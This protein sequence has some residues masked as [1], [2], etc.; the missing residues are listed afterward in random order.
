MAFGKRHSANPEGRNLSRRRLAES[1]K[2]FYNRIMRNTFFV[3]FFSSFLAAASLFLFVSGAAAE[4]EDPCAGYVPPPA[5]SCPPW[6]EYT[7]GSACDGQI[8]TRQQIGVAVCVS[9]GPCGCGGYACRYTPTPWGPTGIT[10]HPWQACAPQ[11]VLRSLPTFSCSGACLKTPENPRYYDNPE[12]SNQ[13]DK[14][15]DSNNI[16]LPVKLDWDDIEGWGQEDG[17]QSYAMTIDNTKDGQ[18]SKVLQI[19]E[20]N[21]RQENGA[22]FLNSNTDVKWNVSGC[23][24][25][26]GQNCGPSSDWSFTTNLAPEPISPD[27]PD[28]AGPRKATTTTPIPVTLEWCGV[29]EAESY[30]FR[31]Y[32]IEAGKKVCHP[33]LITT[34]GSKEICE[35]WL[36]KKMRRGEE[37]GKKLFS[38]FPDED[39]FFFTKNT[40]YSW[41][42][43]TCTDDNGL[44]C[45]DYS[46]RWTFTTGEKELASTFLIS[47]PDD[48]SGQKPVGLPVILDWR[49]DAGI[50]SWKYK[51][52]SGQEEFASVSQSRLFDYPEL[53]LNT[54]YKWQVL[55]CWDFEGKDCRDPWSDI[56]TF[57]TTGQAPKLIFPASSATDIPIPVEFDWEDVSGA[58][59]YIISVQG[60]GLNIEK[61][62][63]ESNFSADFPALPIRQETDYSWEVKTC[64]REDGKV[65]GSYSGSQNFKTFRLAAPARP[66]YPQDKGFL[67]TDERF[68]SWEKVVGAKAYQYE[69]K[70]LSLA[71]NEESKNCSASPLATTLANSG[72]IELGCLGQYQWQVRSCLDENCQEISNWSN[73]WIFNLSEGGVGQGGLVPCDTRT[74]NPNTPWNE[75]EPCQIKH[76]FLLIKIIVDFI[77]LRVAPVVFVLMIMATGAI[78]YTSLGKVTTMAQVISLWKAVGVGIAIIFFAWLIVNAALRLAGYNIGIFGNWYQLSQ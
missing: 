46:Q 22:C 30:R 69:A 70:L 43:L 51:I 71:P 60:D 27:D 59:S 33:N 72:Y 63:T 25:A 56:Y 78:F 53:S 39:L 45:G 24:S 76:I 35:P 4:G 23:C 68:L 14:S 41:D 75:R 18:F 3:L 48:P 8:L 44:E 74:N 47:P 15:R 6:T 49:K 50:N 62:V 26:D 54:L 7:C 29:K 57:K 67:F 28:W 32:I 13:P 52:N 19:S 40:T 9:Q 36:V 20:Y 37:L 34:E 64:A 12:Y 65:C 38:D 77:L 5:P 11:G 17:P 31:T 61:M 21:P 58:K 55:S 42:I 16:P 10:G 1:G 2:K 66:S 73:P